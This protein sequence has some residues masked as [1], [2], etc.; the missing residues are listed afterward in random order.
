MEF[1]IALADIGNPAP[2]T[3]VK[4]TAMV[5]NS[6]YNFLSNQ[7]LGGLPAPHGNLGGDGTGG[8]IGVLS[9]VDLSAIAG[10]QFFSITVPESTSPCDLNG[11]GAVDA[12]DAGILFGDWGNSP[13]SIADKNGDG[14]VDAADAG[15]L[16][17]AWTG[18]ANVVGVP[19]PAQ[20]IWSLVIGMACLLR[21]RR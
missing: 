11:D 4:V 14:V 1:S 6:N 10:D 3:T 16:F 9:G 15:E 8:F 2:G 19:E 5:N 21:Q 12:A 18:D 17:A 7:L 13:N 20:A